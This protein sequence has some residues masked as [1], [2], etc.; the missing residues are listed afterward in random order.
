M[1]GADRAALPAL[2]Q[3]ETLCITAAQTRWIARAA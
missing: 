2:E 1:G 3:G